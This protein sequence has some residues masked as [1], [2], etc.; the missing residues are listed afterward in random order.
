MKKKFRELLGSE[1][2]EMM[3]WAAELG[4]HPEVTPEEKEQSKETILKLMEKLRNRSKK[5]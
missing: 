1:E 5:L 3:T 2:F 4:K